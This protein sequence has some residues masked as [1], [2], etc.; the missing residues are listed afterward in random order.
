MMLVNAVKLSVEPEPAGVYKIQ[1][2]NHSLKETP[3]H[4]HRIPAARHFALTLKH[5]PLR[6]DR[7]SIRHSCKQ[8]QK[9]RRHVV[10]K[11]KP[12]GEKSK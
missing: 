10:R 3:A 11:V 1:S 12:T 8:S 6:S 7:R 5:R 4:T 2:A 9:F